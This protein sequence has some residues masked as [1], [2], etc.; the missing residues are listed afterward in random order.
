MDI[1]EAKFSPRD[2]VIITTPKGKQHGG[3]IRARFNDGTYQVHCQS[4]YVRVPETM[5]TLASK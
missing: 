3:I 1:N 2:R 4:G 5:L